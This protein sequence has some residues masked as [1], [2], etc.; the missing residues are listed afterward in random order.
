MSEAHESE[1]LEFLFAQVCKL[2]HA[3]VQTLLEAIGLYRG[4]P[5]VLRALWAQDGL[6]H[7]DLARTLEVQPATITKMINRMEKNGFVQR[8]QD[9]DDQRVWRVYV[10][11]AGRAVQED[12]RQVWRMLEQEAFEGF[13]MEERVLLRRFFLQI[14]ENLV[15]ASGD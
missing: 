6:T 14:R 3:R 4:Q 11:E 10:T 8:R 12:V 9:A 13:T 5:P 1:T 2:K 15:R 7:T